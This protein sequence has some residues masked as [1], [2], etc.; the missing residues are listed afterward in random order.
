MRAPRLLRDRRGL[1]LVELLV[2]TAILGLVAASVPVL[3]DTGLAGLA[4]Q[5]ESVHR[6]LTYGV[7]LEEWTRDVAGAS[8][9][10]E[11]TDGVVLTLSEGEIRYL[12]K[13]VEV[14]REMRKTGVATWKAVPMRPLASLESGTTLAFQVSAGSAEIAFLGLKR[15]LRA[16]AAFRSVAP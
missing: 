13:G 8:T 10:V 11:I 14:Y 6:E 16:V 12:V 9:A 2:S 3:M 4:I 7:L 15:P 5:R 1:T